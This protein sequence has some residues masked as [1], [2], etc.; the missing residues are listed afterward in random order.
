MYMMDIQ[1][2]SI[3]D[4]IFSDNAVRGFRGFEEDLS[5]VSSSGMGGSIN[6]QK[7]ALS[8]RNTTFELSYAGR[9]GGLFVSGSSL[10]S[11]QG[12]TFRDVTGLDDGGCMYVINTPVTI[13]ASSL[14]ACVARDGDGGAVY[15]DRGSLDMRACTV[16]EAA[17]YRGG[18]VASSKAKVA[19]TGACVFACADAMC[20]R[21]VCSA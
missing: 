3:Q 9:G 14:R 5:Q 11:L 21:S 13:Q 6:C 4:T 2:S 18:L 16:K 10:L 8:L 1:S 15:M 17:A 19:I 20:R 12:C 7:T